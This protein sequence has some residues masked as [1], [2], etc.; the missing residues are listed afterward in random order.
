MFL[1]KHLV[2]RVPNN[3]HHPT[4][5]KLRNTCQQCQFLYQDVQKL[6]KKS[7]TVSEEQK[8]IRSSVVLNIRSSVYFYSLACTQTEGLVN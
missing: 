4:R 5:D 6:L 2:T 3:I 8:L 1:R 7:E